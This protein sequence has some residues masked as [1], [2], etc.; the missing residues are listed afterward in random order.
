MLAT[1]RATDSVFGLAGDEFTVLLEDMSDSLDDAHL[2]E[3]KL[4][5]NIALPVRIGE[6]SAEVGAS[7]G[8]AIHCPSSKASAAELIK[9][10]DHRMYEAKRAGRDQVSQPQQPRGLEAPGLQSYVVST[11][12][13]PLKPRR[14]GSRARRA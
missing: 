6:V 1:V 7:I 10:A 14:D 8:I 5:A 4:I 2:V 3:R 11:A 12:R 9:E 13:S